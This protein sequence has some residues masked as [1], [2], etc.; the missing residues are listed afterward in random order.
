MICWI[1]R[2]A[3]CE[4]TLESI[5]QG[6]ERGSNGWTELMGGPLSLEG[7]GMAVKKTNDHILSLLRWP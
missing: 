3:G 7:E 1:S 6:E 2:L 4:V 5:K